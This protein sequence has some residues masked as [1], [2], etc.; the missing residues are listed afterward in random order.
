VD[1]YLDLHAQRV[2][3]SELRPGPPAARLLANKI[4]N[5]A[6]VDGMSVSEICERGWSGLTHRPVL[7]AGIEELER[8]N[9]VRILRQRPGPRGGRPSELLLINP[10]IKSG[11]DGSRED[12]ENPPEGGFPGFSGP[13][14]ERF[15]RKKPGGEG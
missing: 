5:G 11:G 15:S 14:D 12:P 4:R 3:A 7:Y 10:A 1:E 9:W 13:S 2:Y 6:I 8:I